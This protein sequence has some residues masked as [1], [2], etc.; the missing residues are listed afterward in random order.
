MEACIG[1]LE[2]ISVARGI[3]AA[4]AMLKESPVR[5]RFSRP[6]QPGRYATL[7]SGEVEEVR[8]AYDRGRAVAAE[9]LVDDL[10]L[11]NAHPSIFT[12]YETPSIVG[13][14][15]LGIL[16]ALTLASTLVAADAAAKT[17]SARLALVRLANGLGG[18]GYFLIEGAVE[19]VEASIDAAAARVEPEDLLQSRVVI[20]RVHPELI[21]FLLTHDGMEGLARGEEELG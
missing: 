15:A 20:P 13:H 12:A 5:L 18:K 1:L 21:D 10:F 16:E 4:D 17:T 9:K 2:T 8:R 11:P 3:A 7:F 19:D 6:I 14:D